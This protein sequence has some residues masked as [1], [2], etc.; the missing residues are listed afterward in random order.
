MVRLTDHLDK[1]IA[2]DWD[3]KPQTK[4]KH[5]YLLTKIKIISGVRPL[6]SL[7]APPLQ[8]SIWLKAYYFIST[9]LASE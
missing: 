3:V 5:D 7:R 1:T 6:V 4:P 8:T 9:F 2:A